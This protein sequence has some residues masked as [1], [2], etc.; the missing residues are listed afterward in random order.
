MENFKV[1]MCYT[2]KYSKQFF[3]QSSIFSIIFTKIWTCR[4][5]HDN[6]DI[7]ID[8][9]TITLNAMRLIYI[10]ADSSSQLLYVDSLVYANR[11]KL[12]YSASES[13][14]RNW[15][16]GGSSTCWACF[17]SGASSKRNKRSVVLAIK[18]KVQ[19]IIKS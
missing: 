14:I 18:W 12:R 10:P 5:I 4:K 3:Y 15:R 13:N 8:N 1:Q 11:H 9:V 6:N 7:G 16:K 19:F 17:N 2:I